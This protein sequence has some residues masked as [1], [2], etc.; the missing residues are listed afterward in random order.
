MGSNLWVEDA[1]KK[2]MNYDYPAYDKRKAY[3]GFANMQVVGRKKETI[4]EAARSKTYRGQEMKGSSLYRE[5][6]MDQRTRFM[7]R[8][9]EMKVYGG[10]KQ[11]NELVE[12]LREE[13]GFGMDE[14]ENDWLNI[15][16]IDSNKIKI[17]KYIKWL[18]FK[19]INKK[20]VV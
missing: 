14:T 7:S 18:N 9:E 3:S 8:K 12:R 5:E 10:N 6:D 20:Y 16:V 4:Y 1:N 13:K 15:V 11:K 2:F 19:F 17:S